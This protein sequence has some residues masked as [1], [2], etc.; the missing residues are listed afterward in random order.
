MPESSRRATR[1][2]PSSGPRMNRMRLLIEKSGDTCPAKPMR[3]VHVLGAGLLLNHLERLG[4]DLAGDLEVGAGRG[5]EA[6]H[7]LARID[8]REQFGPEPGA[9]APEQRGAD[10]Q[11]GRHHQPAPAAPASRRP[12]QMRPAP[13]QRKKGRRDER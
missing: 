8:L 2:C 3:D 11:V 6:D 1:I 9:Q 5:A 13:A 10:N 4:P 7:E 12:R